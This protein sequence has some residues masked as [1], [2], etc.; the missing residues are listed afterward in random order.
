MKTSDCKQ[1]EIHPTVI[2]KCTNLKVQIQIKLQTK[3]IQ[4]T[5]PSFNH[6]ST[7]VAIVVHKSDRHMT[8]IK[9]IWI[10]VEHRQ[11]SRSFHKTVQRVL[12]SSIKKN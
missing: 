10:K 7:K 5:H 4:K 8:C 2:P 6:A 3:H 9:I 1:N 12:L 11:T